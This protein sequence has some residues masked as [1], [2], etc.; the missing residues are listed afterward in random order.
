MMAGLTF[1]PAL[2]NLMLRR[3]PPG[4]DETTQCRQCTIDTGSGGTEVKNLK[5]EQMLTKRR[6]KVNILIKNALC[7][8]RKTRITR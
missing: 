1:L 4:N 7:R 3:R 5:C 2:L 8:D 6:F